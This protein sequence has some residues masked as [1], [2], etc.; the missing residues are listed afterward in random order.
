MKKTILAF[1]ALTVATCTFTA[2][3]DEKNNNVK[4]EP[5]TVKEV[6]T[7]TEAE[8]IAVSDVPTESTSDEELSAEAEKAL[9]CSAASLLSKAENSA[10]CEMVEAQKLPTPGYAYIISS[11]ESKNYN[12]PDDFDISDFK[13][14]TGG[15]IE[16]DISNLEWFSVICEDQSVFSTV[17]NPT[18][19]EFVGT[20][21]K[22]ILQS[23]Y[24]GEIHEALTAKVTDD[25][26]FDKVYETCV[27]V[28]SNK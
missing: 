8:N 19:P 12:V 23:V 1:I 15:F 18:K 22:T 27:D 6:E 28:I 25:M 26:P 7:T 4:T 3:G 11:D 13:S 14:R 10:L 24:G 9:M 16:Q 5:T 2:C 20:G 21:P 17:I